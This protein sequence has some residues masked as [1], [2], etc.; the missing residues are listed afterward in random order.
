GSAPTCRDDAGNMK[1]FNWKPFLSQWARELI[2]REAERRHGDIPRD[3]VESSWLGLPGA[4]DSQIRSAESRL[5]TRL[6]PS[7]RAFLK[8][9]N[10][11][12]QV[13]DWVPASAG[14]LLP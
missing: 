6:P 1:P 8:A 3:V 4:T 5:G 7:Y 2:R 11:W 9:T 13:R 12:R 14:R 10:G